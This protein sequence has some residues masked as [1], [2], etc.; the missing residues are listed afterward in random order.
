MEIKDQR[1]VREI[2]IGTLEIQKYQKVKQA[3]KLGGKKIENYSGGSKWKN[4]MDRGAWWI[5]K[6]GTWL[7][8]FSTHEHS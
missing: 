8:Q 3:M 6:N 4:P 7:K 1:V 5:P 2:W